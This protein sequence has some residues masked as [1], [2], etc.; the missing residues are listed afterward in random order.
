ME[1]NVIERRTSSVHLW[2]ETKQSTVSS[3]SATAVP[4]YSN[5]FVTSPSELESRKTP[6]NDAVAKLNIK[7]KHDGKQQDFTFHFHLLLS[8]VSKTKILSNRYSF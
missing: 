8:T 1:G 5:I 6:E 2:N 4:A 3:A 7:D